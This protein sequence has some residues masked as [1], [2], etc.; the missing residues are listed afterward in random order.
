ME[1]V[2]RGKLS[3]SCF[4]RNI[5]AATKSYE[6]EPTVLIIRCFSFRVLYF[7]YF[8]ICTN[9]MD[10]KLTQSKATGQSRKHQKLD[11]SE[12]YEHIGVRISISNNICISV[13]IPFPG[14]VSRTCLPNDKGG[15]CVGRCP[16]SAEK[17]IGGCYRPSYQRW[18]M[19]VKQQRLPVNISQY[20]PGM[21]C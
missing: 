6:S 17:L 21:M 1:T 19:N 11:W 9:E 5:I 10:A 13:R 16:Q 7:H 18:S 20:I 2:S 12:A 3:D 14:G 15:Q 4:I 8:Q